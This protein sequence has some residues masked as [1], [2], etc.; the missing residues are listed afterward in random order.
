MAKF[1]VLYWRD[2]PLQVRARDRSGRVSQPLPDRFQQAVDKA[3]MQAGLTG[4]QD[5]LDQLTW[6]DPQERA[7]SAAAV[8]AAVAAELDRQFPE[9]DWRKT[10]ASA[11]HSS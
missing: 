8:A 3:S 10:A 6:S 5:Y 2:I 4:D 9:I 1:Q 7:G 11:D